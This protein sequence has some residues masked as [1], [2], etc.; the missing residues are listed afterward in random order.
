MRKC[1]AELEMRWRRRGEEEK[2]VL[3]TLATNQTALKYTVIRTV[4]QQYRK[5]GSGTL[6]QYK[7]YFIKYDVLVRFAKEHPTVNDGA[8]RRLGVSLVPLC[9]R[10]G[11]VEQGRL[12]GV[13]V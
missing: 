13:P 9:D 5:T 6:S 2:S 10:G 11:G 4:N 7:Y 3:L 8:D 12:A 1:V